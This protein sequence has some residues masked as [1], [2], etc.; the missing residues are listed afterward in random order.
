MGP[1][2]NILDIRPRFRINHTFDAD[3]DIFLVS[4]TGIVIPLSTDNGGSGDNYGSGAATCAGTPT[5]FADSAAT[6][7][8]AGAP[9]FAGTFKPESPLN[10]VAGASMTGTWKLRIRDDFGADA[11]TIFCFQLGI[12]R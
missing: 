2:G 12:T 3:L 1:S 8:T 4:P 9:P 6:L 11:G 10:T 5:I 7:I